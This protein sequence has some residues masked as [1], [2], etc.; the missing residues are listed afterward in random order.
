MTAWARRMWERRGRG[1]RWVG[2]LLVLALLPGLARLPWADIGAVLRGLSARALVGLVGLNALFLLVSTWRWQVLLRAA[3]PG[4]TAV[5]WPR[6]LMYRLAGF[7]VSYFTPG[8]QF[9]GEPLQVYALHRRERVPAAAA[10]A[11]VGLDRLLDLTANTG[12]VLLALAWLAP[13]R[14]GATVRA[15]PLVLLLAAVFGGW[16]GLCAVPWPPTAAGW[17]GTLAQAAA[18]CRTQPRALLAA[19]GLSVLA[20][21]VLL[22]EYHWMLRALG[23]QPTGVQTV[24]MMLAARLAFLVPVPAG[25]GALEVGQ[26][27]AAQW[28][29]W[30]AAYGAALS[31]L[32][33]A[34][35]GVIGGLG[36]L[37]SRRLWP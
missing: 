22:A 15:W 33:R 28:V 18:L 23:L 3:H 35:D 32:I 34:R 7:A 27:W 29:G 10:W 19:A 21:A 6:L 14:A 30:P 16:G 1:W 25:A 37:F 5:P 36:L 26:V 8:T 31:L 11:S 12:F 13:W 17:R 2:W 4:R 24:T 9:G 20:W